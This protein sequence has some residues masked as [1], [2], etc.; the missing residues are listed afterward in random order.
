MFKDKAIPILRFRKI[1]L[2]FLLKAGVKSRNRAVHLTSSVRYLVI[3]GKSGVSW[4]KVSSYL[5][6]IDCLLLLV[7][8]RPIKKVFCSSF[9]NWWIA[10]C[11]NF[12]N[13]FKV[14]RTSLWKLTSPMLSVL[15]KGWGSSWKSIISF[16]LKRK[17]LHGSRSWRSCN[18]S[19]KLLELTCSRNPFRSKRVLLI[20]SS[21]ILR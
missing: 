17:N 2:I 10:C 1:C 3:L 5:M 15:V 14:R 11:K 13:S 8:L 20:E 9:W 21:D 12:T 19:L 7:L 4:I 16:L 18:N 6:K